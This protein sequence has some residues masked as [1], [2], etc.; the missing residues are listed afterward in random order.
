MM[1][2]HTVEC[3]ASIRLRIGGDGP[4]SRVMCRALSSCIV[5]RASCVV[6]PCVP[7][8]ITSPFSGPHLPPPVPR[9][10]HQVPH[11][12][13]RSHPT[14]LWYTGTLRGEIAV[15]RN[16]PCQMV[17]LG[18]E[19][20][21]FTRGIVQNGDFNPYFGVRYARAVGAAVRFVP[22]TGPR[23]APSLPR[24]LYTGVTC[25]LLLLIALLNIP[26]ASVRRFLPRSAFCS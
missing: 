25:A 15:I 10:P 8:G 22:V 14:L 21:D 11:H 13:P 18:P 24:V 2:E 9:L 16:S 26:V 3:K 23:G 6:P 12:S 17:V 4:H 19:N 7:S 20:G 1:A 5:F